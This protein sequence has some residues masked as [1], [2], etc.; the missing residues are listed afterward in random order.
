MNNL[1]GLMWMFFL[2]GIF[3]FTS[4]TT[5]DDDFTADPCPRNVDEQLVFD[6]SGSKYFY[7]F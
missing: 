7:A 2:G 6:H 1:K 4:C 5:G 3:F